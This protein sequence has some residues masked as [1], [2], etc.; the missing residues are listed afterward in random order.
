MNRSHS[1]TDSLAERPL[2]V[3]VYPTCLLAATEPFAELLAHETDQTIK[4]L[5]SDNI[6]TP[7]LQWFVRMDIAQKRRKW[8]YAFLPFLTC[9]L[10]GG[11]TETVVP[12]AVAWNLLHLAAHL[13]DD[14]ADEGFIVGPQGKLPSGEDVTVATTLLF[15]AQAALDRLPATGLPLAV[16][17]EL[18]QELNRMV[19]RM[20]EGQHQDLTALSQPDSTQA[21]YWQIAAAKTGDFLGWASQ[22]GARVGGSQEAEAQTCAQFGQNL[23]L[24]LQIMDDWHDLVQHSCA[25]DLT[26]GKRTLPVLYALIV[27]SPAQKQ[28]LQETLTAVPLDPAGETAVRQ[29]IIELGGLQYVLA[30]AAIRYRRAQDALGAFPDSAVKSHLLALLTYAFPFVGDDGSQVER[31][32]P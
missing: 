6:L 18:R 11:C 19:I 32:A 26:Q 4:N 30:Q 7:I 23:G 3:G 17:W 25:S 21:L 1:V 29:L 16:A 8:P 12:L 27:A 2:S 13:L 9:R 15:L 24:L 10:V 14:I 31:S 28:W 20:C 5:N 22:A